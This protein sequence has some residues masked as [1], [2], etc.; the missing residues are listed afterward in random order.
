LVLQYHN[1]EYY[2]ECALSYFVQFRSLFSF[3]QSDKKTLW[4]QA[5]L[6]H[7]PSI[8]HEK[9]STKNLRPSHKILIQVLHRPGEWEIDCI[10]K[11]RWGKT[12]KN[13]R[14]EQI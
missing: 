8:A 13:I 7:H 14:K 6:A 5:Q 11:Y 4:C 2:R 9:E 12:M 1:L 3:V 10:A